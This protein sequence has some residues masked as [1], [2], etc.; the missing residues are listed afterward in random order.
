M[1][2]PTQRRVPR[3]IPVLV[4]VLLAGMYY[5]AAYIDSSGP[6]E[7]VNNFYH[8]YFNKDFDT[9]AQNLSVFWGVR[10]LPQYTSMQPAE[11]LKNRAEIEKEVGTILKST[12]KD[13]PIPANTSIEILKENTKVGKNSAIVVYDIKENGK[14]IFTEAAILINEL[15]KFRILEM[16]PIDASNLEQLKQIDINTLDKNFETL[17]N[18]KTE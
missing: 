2:E 5:Y 9:V 4:L 18:T 6:E 13:N 7:T 11:L 1:N 15:N 12:E 10:L 3:F 17:L 14:K 16:I 8:A